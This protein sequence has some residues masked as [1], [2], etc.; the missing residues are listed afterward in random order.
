MKLY[1]TDK[2]DPFVGIF[3]Q[4]YTI[5]TPLTDESSL[6][7]FK[8]FKTQIENLYNEFAEGD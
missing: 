7:D 8:W 4:T 6:N 3:E 5:E 1:I 2:G